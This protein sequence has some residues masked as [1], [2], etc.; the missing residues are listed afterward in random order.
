[1][2][3][4]E[5][6]QHIFGKA[7][8]TSGV[9]W[10]VPIPKRGTQ[11]VKIKFDGDFLTLKADGVPSVT[12]PATQEK[13]IYRRGLDQ[14]RDGYDDQRPGNP[15]QRLFIYACYA[16]ALELM[17]GMPNVKTVKVA[18]CELARAEAGYTF[19]WR[20]SLVLNDGTKLRWWI[21]EGDAKPNEHPPILNIVAHEDEERFP[22]AD[23]CYVP[24]SKV[25]E[26]LAAK[27]QNQIERHMSAYFVQ[28]KALDAI[29]PKIR[30]SF[31]RTKTQHTGITHSVFAYPGSPKHGFLIEVAQGNRNPIK[32]EAFSM[33]GKPHRFRWHNVATVK[34][35]VCKPKFRIL[36]EKEQQK[37]QR[38]ETFCAEVERETLGELQAALLALNIPFE[39][40]AFSPI[41]T[42]R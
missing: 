32:I 8:K 6:C 38:I 34:S 15:A 33:R 2:T 36:S 27:I 23:F 35:M 22:S 19:E 26:K 9:H 30:A 12:I 31:M 11:D 29:M 25:N 3:F 20:T 17:R 40:P 37:A 4:Q 13:V 42:E 14:F 24:L 28:K 21:Q 5:H 41:L 7:I 10:L 1:M 39:E 18:K 16:K